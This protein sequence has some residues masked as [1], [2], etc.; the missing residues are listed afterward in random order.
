MVGTGV[1]LLLLLLLRISMMMTTTTML[2]LMMMKV[3]VV[4]VVVVVMVIMM[5]T[6]TMFKMADPSFAVT[7][8]FSHFFP[9][10]EE[11]LDGP[12]AKNCL[13]QVELPPTLEALLL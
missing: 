2:M 3:V 1:A 13:S 10:E 5:V 4:V 6:V 7:S 8:H 12:R 9:G 11:N